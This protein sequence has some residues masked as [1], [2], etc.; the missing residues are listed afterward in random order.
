M[1]VGN[2]GEQNMFQ[3]LK[4]PGEV[5]ENTFWCTTDNHYNDLRNMLQMDSMSFKG[6]KKEKGD[7]FN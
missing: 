7:Y 4:S 6:K 3:M 5:E 1:M 2:G